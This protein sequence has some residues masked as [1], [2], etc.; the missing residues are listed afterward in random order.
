MRW[1]CKFNVFIPGADLEVL[2][3]G[4]TFHNST[5]VDV[6]AASR[7]LQCGLERWGVRGEGGGGR[8]EG[9]GRG[10]GEGEEEGGRGEGGG[11]RGEGEE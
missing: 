8:S 10:E 1:V 5:P 11:V 4:S 2:T 6:P 3:D 9:G 7:V